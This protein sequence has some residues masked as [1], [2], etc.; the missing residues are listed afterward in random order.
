MGNECLSYHPF[1]LPSPSDVANHV[2]LRDNPAVRL[3]EARAQAIDRENLLL[4]QSNARAVT[5][6]SRKLDGLP[7]AME[8]SPRHV[9]AS[10]P[11]E[12]IAAH[13][14]ES[15]S[16]LS[17]QIRDQAPRQ[18]SMQAALDWS[19]DVLD[20]TQQVLMRR[21][22]IFVGGCTLESV[23]AVCGPGTMGVSA[24]DSVAEM[25]NVD[26]IQRHELDGGKVRYGMLGII[27]QYA[28]DKLREHRRA[29]RTWST[30][31]L[32]SS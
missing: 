18:R 10:F 32:S 13:L 19:Y 17:S 4:T 29:S 15:L 25:I 26:L 21:L 27:G 6:L 5:E 24:I 14:G 28:R 11:R 1:D 30:D 2:A 7:L 9:P 31:W 23:E 22:G 16:I 8:D 3:F 12:R 20:Q